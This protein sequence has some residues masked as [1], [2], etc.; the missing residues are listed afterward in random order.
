MSNYMSATLLA[1]LVDR[2]ENGVAFSDRAGRVLGEMMP[3]MTER[4][5]WV[6]DNVGYM[7]ELEDEAAEIVERR[8]SALFA[9]KTLLHQRYMERVSKTTKVFELDG[10]GFDE[11][12]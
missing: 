4:E 12:I 7:P 8:R 2:S 11:D 10:D 5:A 1:K 9:A 6:L 3:E